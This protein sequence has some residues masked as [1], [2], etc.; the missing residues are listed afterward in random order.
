MG[1]GRGRSGLLAA[2]LGLALVVAGC[3]TESHENRPRPPVPVP[4][5]VSISPG[6]VLLQPSGVG[7][8]SEPG[9]NISQNEGLQATEANP[10]APLLVTFTVSN[11]TNQRTAL[12]VSDAGEVDE[13]SP[14]PVIAC[15]EEIVPGGT[16]ELRASLDTGNY[17]VSARNIAGGKPVRF[18][19]G[20][21]RPSSQQDLLLP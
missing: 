16:G 7:S 17:Q 15:S 10:K 3:G 8:A 18:S 11:I 5:T 14:C 20:P 1:G 21:N 12:L 19:V 6:G 2:I 9:T 4:V 13:K